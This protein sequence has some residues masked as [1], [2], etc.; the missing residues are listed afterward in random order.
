MHVAVKLVAE[1]KHTNTIIYMQKKSWGA[2][3]E[4]ILASGWNSI[5]R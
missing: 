2:K 1:E 3:K 4:Q 5:I